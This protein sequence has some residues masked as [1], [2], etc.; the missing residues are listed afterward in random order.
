[1]KSNIALIVVFPV[2]VIDFV[3]SRVSINNHRSIR[4][5]LTINNSYIGLPIKDIVK[6]SFFS[7]VT[8]SSLP[9]GTP[10]FC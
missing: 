8:I 7:R 6:D 1:M 4:N 5:D 9:L 3:V 2:P 10:R